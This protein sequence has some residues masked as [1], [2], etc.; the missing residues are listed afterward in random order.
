[1]RQYPFSTLKRLLKVDAVVAFI[2]EGEEEACWEEVQGREEG[3]KVVG[4]ACWLWWCV[5]GS[6]SEE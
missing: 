3:E 1:M 2:W 5:S 4:Q 6:R